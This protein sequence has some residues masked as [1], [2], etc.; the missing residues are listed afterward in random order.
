VLLVNK[1]GESQSLNLP[2]GA[3]AD[4]EYVDQTTGLEPPA[5]AHASGEQLTL[6]AFAVVVAKLP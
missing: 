5:R 1:H 6:K 3:A 2:K 4:L